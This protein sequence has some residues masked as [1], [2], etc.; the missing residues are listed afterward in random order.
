M[1]SRFGYD[2]SSVKIHTD[3]TAR[4]SANAARALAYTVNSD[5]VLGPR[6][7]REDSPAGQRLLAH[8]LAHIVQRHETGTVGVPQPSQADNDADRIATEFADTELPLR[9]MRTP[10]AVLARQAIPGSQPPPRRW[11]SPP[12]RVAQ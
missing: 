3:P 4:E 6:A 9:V 7:P 8:E 5:I 10:P 11:R 12:N 2:F 1:E